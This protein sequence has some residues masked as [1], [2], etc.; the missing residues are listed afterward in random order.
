VSSGAQTIFL[1][2]LVL[3]GGP[4]NIFA[5][6]IASTKDVGA[7]KEA[8]KDKKKH[9][10]DSVDADSLKLW[11]VSCLTLIAMIMIGF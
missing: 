8:I 4:G 6:E 7:L 11:G 1:N 5:I 2:C 10:F 9:A 3:G